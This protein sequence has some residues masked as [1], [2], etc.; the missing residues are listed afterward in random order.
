MSCSGLVLLCVDFPYDCIA[1]SYTVLYLSR[2]CLVL[3]LFSS[4]SFFVR[5][6]K[7]YQYYNHVENMF[8]PNS[9]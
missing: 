4:Y 5:C 2:C 9:Q 3:M 1:D 8:V 7:D 6:K